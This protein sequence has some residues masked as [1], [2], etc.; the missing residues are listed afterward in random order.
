[1]SAPSPRPS[2]A[3]RPSEGNR[4]SEDH[5]TQTDQTPQSSP[6]PQPRTS[7][8]ADPET[9]MTRASRLVMLGARGGSLLGRRDELSTAIAGGRRRPIQPS[10]SPPGLCPPRAVRTVQLFA[11]LS[12][13]GSESSRPRRGHRTEPAH[14]RSSAWTR[15]ATLRHSAGYVRWG[16]ATGT[17]RCRS[18]EAAPWSCSLGNGRPRGWVHA[19]QAGS[20]RAGSRALPGR[21]PWSQGPRKR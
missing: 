3:A 11:P 6:C 7:G 8:A 19:V 4:A 21:C 18:T 15:E 12:T 1:M 2:D 17:A 5:Q 16:M 10:R 20:C 9:E 13:T 14:R